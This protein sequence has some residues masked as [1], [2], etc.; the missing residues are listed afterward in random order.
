ME[1]D[2]PTDKP[3]DEEPV[4]DVPTPP[5]REDFQSLRGHTR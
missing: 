4:I 5:T 1:T 3:R 2:E